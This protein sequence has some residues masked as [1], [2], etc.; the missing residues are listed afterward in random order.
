MKRILIIDDD[1]SIGNMTEE[2]LTKEGYS[3]LRAYSGTEAL[4]VLDAQAKPD[5]ILLDLMLPGISGEEVLTKIS[6]IPVVI[7]SAKVDINDKV[8]RLLDGAADYITK[9]FD[10]RELLA[11]IAVA[12]RQTGPLSDVLRFEEIEMDASSL[13]VHVDGQAVKLTRTEC[14]ILKLLLQNPKQVITKSALLDRISID[15]PDCTESSLKIHA[16]NLRKKLREPGGKDYI[17]AV[18]GIGFKMRE[19]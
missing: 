4:L 14:A 6:G 2:V 5:L 3:V 19:E 11:R 16:S 12:L 1:I 15:T 17:E 9:P 18:W 10:A 13:S 8:G 7:V